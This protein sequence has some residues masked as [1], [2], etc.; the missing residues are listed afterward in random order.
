[1]SETEFQLM[2][3]AL[4]LV[5]C[6]LAASWL[7]LVMQAFFHDKRIGFACAFG[8]AT[9][10]LAMAVSET[11]SHALLWT[12]L[13]INLILIGWFVVRQARRPVVY[14]PAALLLL[15]SGGACWIWWRL[16]QVGLV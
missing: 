7:V 11:L 4:A 13:A 12:L 16:T 2:S 1:L 6:G 14:I 5:V 8:G 3:W 9:A 15:S 10:A